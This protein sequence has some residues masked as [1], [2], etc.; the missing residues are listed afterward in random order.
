MKLI[1]NAELR[2]LRFRFSFLAPDE[3]GVFGLGDVG[4]VYLSGEISDR[5]HAA[6][7]G[8]IWVS[9]LHRSNPVSLA[10]ARSPE[11]TGLYLRAGFL[12]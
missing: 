3:F 2:L 12:S 4:R 10:Y 8:G 5:W 7:G 1:G 6:A 11:S 9:F